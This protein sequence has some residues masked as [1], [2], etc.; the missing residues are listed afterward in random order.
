M[1]EEEEEGKA[2]AE[3][4]AEVHVAGARGSSRQRRQR[5]SSNP[6]DVR[7]CRGSPLPLPVCVF[8]LVQFQCLR[9]R[10]VTM[11]AIATSTASESADA[12]RLPCSV[13]RP[14][15]ALM[16]KGCLDMWVV[17]CLCSWS[18]QNH[19]TSKIMKMTLLLDT[20]AQLRSPAR[21]SSCSALLHLGLDVVMNQLVDHGALQHTQHTG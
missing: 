10:L 13:P 19:R 4:S 15:P 21:S 9:A 3:E 17:V 12:P 2:E 1:E 20:A 11:V 6:H 18:L 7:A 8:C 16:T 14:L 5:R